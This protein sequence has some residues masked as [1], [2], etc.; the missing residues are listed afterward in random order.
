MQTDIIFIFSE[1]EAPCGRKSLDYRGRWWPKGGMLL[2]TYWHVVILSSQL[3]K[4]F[5]DK[6]ILI[7]S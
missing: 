7:F 4:Y 6:V 1:R 5:P 2:Q 3:K